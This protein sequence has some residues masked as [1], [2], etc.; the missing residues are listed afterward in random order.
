MIAD[1]AII[2]GV[3]SSIRWSTTVCSAGVDDDAVS[4]SMSPS[5]RDVRC[6][7]SARPAMA[8]SLASMARREG[9][10]GRVCGRA[11]VAAEAEA[12]GGGGDA[13]CSRLPWGGE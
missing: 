1:R 9:C 8:E 2:C 5:Y 12:G 7:L 6:L 3:D 13:E 4:S 10:V 11:V